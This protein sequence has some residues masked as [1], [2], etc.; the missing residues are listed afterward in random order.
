LPQ[1][2]IFT[3]QTA[4]Y[5]REF[6]QASFGCCPLGRNERRVRNIKNLQTLKYLEKEA[7]HQLS[8]AHHNL[9]HAR[10][11]AT[12]NALPGN[13]VTS[14]LKEQTNEP[15]NNIVTEDRL[16]P[17]PK[18]KKRAVPS[19]FSS[20]HHRKPHSTTDAP[21]SMLL[22]NE[23]KA[24]L[25]RGEETHLLT[26]PSPYG[27]R[28]I[29]TCP[30]ECFNWC[31]PLGTIPRA[32]TESSG[33]CSTVSDKWRRVENIITSSAAQNINVERDGTATT[34]T[35]EYPLD[36]GV[37]DIPSDFN[38]FNFVKRTIVSFFRRI[39]DWCIDLWRVN[40]DWE[41][42]SA[43]AVVTFTSRQAALAA[44]H[45]LTD[46]RGQNQWMTY[47]SLPVP[48]LADTAPCDIIT[49]RN[50]CRPVTVT[51]GKNHVLVRNCLSGTALV[52]IYCFYVSM[53]GRTPLP[54]M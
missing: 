36:D 35:N 5:S 25:F 28:K 52:L 22:D 18:S 44:R 6:A 39:T 3:E 16:S 32:S 30:D 54:M 53:I 29:T 40:K 11:R 19:R 13:Y 12:A 45:C 14:F 20:L 15:I 4:I 23:G 31:N 34:L 43:Y 41:S 38:F 51:L 26:E 17:T 10:K 24:H 49:C 47:E 42:K 21:E 8:D 48:P 1:S 2:T 7:L 50:C 46:G 27:E 33:K 37:W 9:L